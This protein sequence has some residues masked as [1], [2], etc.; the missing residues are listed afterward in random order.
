MRNLLQKIP[1]AGEFAIVIA[2]AFGL[3]IISSF[4]LALHPPTGAMHSEPG[5]WRMVVQEVIVFIVLG[6][7][8]RLRGWTFERV[9]L[10][11]HWMDGLHG[12]G[13]AAAA[14]LAFYAAL[15]ALTTLSP[16][17]AAAAAKIQVIPAGLTPWIVAAVVIVNSFYEEVFVSGYVITALKEKLGETIAINVSVAIRLSYHLYQGVIGIIGIIPVGLIFGYWYARTGKLW[18]LIVAHAAIDLVGF[19]ATVKF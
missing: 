1:L 6:S 11:S 14:Y 12:L 5:L 7:F 9:G 2:G 4:Y 13:L 17:T 19:L 10:Q 18:P 16:H 3:S 15:V 8:L